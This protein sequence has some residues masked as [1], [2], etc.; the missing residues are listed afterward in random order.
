MRSSLRYQPNNKMRTDGWLF[1][2]II[3]DYA[4]THEPSLYAAKAQTHRAIIEYAYTWSDLMEL[5]WSQ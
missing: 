2:F 1:S 3:V 4:H 5:Q